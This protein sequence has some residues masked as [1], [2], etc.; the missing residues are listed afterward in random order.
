MCFIGNKYI[1]I[2]MP[3]IINC[4]IWMRDCKLENNLKC[5]YLVDTNFEASYQF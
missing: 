4:N 2:V 5:F 3:D 1:K